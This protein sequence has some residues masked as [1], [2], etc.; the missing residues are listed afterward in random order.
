LDNKQQKYV[1]N[2]KSSSKYITNLVNDLTDFS[3]L[4][5]NKISI[6]QKAFNPKELVDNTC[7][8]LVP[9]AENKNIKLNWTTEESLNSNFVSD[10]HRI[11]QILTNLVT[12]A[13]K[14]TQEGGVNVSVTREKEYIIFKVTDSGIGI[15]SNQTKNIFNEFQQAHDGI[16]KKFGGTGLGLNISKRMIE[17]L[18]G[19][20]HVDSVLN[21]GSTFTFTIPIIEA[22][23]DANITVHSN[24]LQTVFHS[25]NEI[26][27]VVIDDDK[28]QLQLMEEI[29]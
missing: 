22:E 3:R 5:N 8:I 11:K 6:Q 4:E 21:E 26:N 9:N 13:I 7:N 25:L 19:T 17:L 23:E 2:I 20:I 16:E 24:D 29:L 10:P 27:I 12:N 18:G 15:A 28:V 14:F 1:N